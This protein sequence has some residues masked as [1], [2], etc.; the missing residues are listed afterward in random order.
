M[1]TR[2]TLASL[3]LAA[4]FTLPAHAELQARFLGGSTTANAYYDT[5]LN[6]T[7]LANANLIAS[8]TFGLN[9]GVDY[10]DD[11]YGYGSWI[12]K[13]GTATWGGAEKW[14]AAMDSAS[15]LGFSDWRLP[16][17]A[18]V[19]GTAF[20]YN[21][22]SSNGSVDFGYNVSAPGTAYAGSTGSE[23][24]NLFFDTLGNKAYLDMNGHPQSGWGLTHT[25]PFQNFQSYLYWSGTE[26]APSTD[27]AWNFSTS[28][29]SQ[30]AYYKS[31]GAYALVV[32]SGDVAA[33]VPEP[34]T[35]ALLLA[36]L[37]LFGLIEQR[38]K[39]SA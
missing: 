15:Y 8:N 29:G 19:N 5:N 11:Q 7:W 37:G 33:A 38:R 10:G 3:L 9:Y 32:R 34:E 12:F 23:M 24:A 31:G 14:I 27:V 1:N 18:P 13:D 21:S 30:G 39:K 36:G 4:T 17:V 2:L 28:Y 25:G 26:Y 6:V 20:N 35:Y 22:T 16:T